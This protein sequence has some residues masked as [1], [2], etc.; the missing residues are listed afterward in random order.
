MDTPGSNIF[1]SK[2]FFSS[3][4]ESISVV[5]VVCEARDKSQSYRNFWQSES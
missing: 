3:I 5:S 2:H 1:S 4:S